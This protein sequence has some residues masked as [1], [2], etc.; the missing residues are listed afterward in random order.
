[1]FGW[2]DSTDG[3]IKKGSVTDTIY[4]FDKKSWRVANEIESKVG[5]CVAAIADS[6]GL[7]GYSYYKCVGNEWKP[8][9]EKLNH[10]TMKD[11][12]DGQVYKTIGIGNQLWMAENLNYADSVNFSGMLGGSW[13]YEN[14]ESNCEKSGRLYNWYAAMDRLFLEEHGMMCDG[15]DSTDSGIILSTFR[16]ACKWSERVYQGVCPSGWHLPSAKEWQVALKFIYGDY[17]ENQ[18]NI[19][20]EINNEYGFF[21]AAPEGFFYNNSMFSSMGGYWSSTLWGKDAY[22]VTIKYKVRLTPASDPASGVNDAFSVRCIKDED[23]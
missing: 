20:F 3:T 4:V 8:T 6:V 9:A 21:D 16:Y 7:A 13:C 18:K 22:V 11:S 10:G 2:K 23:E 17:D 15:V 12:R 19:S 14:D 1:M 5:G